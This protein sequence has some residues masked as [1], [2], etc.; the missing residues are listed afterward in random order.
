VLSAVLCF[1]LVLFLLVF[2]NEPPTTEIAT[3]ALH[4][5]LPTWPSLRSDHCGR[6][7]IVTSSVRSCVC[8][9]VCVCVFVCVCVCVVCVMGINA[10]M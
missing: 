6:E 3:L 2:C 8:V 4:D 5:A 9:C 10:S 1:S 7:H